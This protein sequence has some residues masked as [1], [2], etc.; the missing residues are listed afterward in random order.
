MPGPDRLILG[1]R[2]HG[3]GSARSVVAALD[4]AAPDCVL[5]EGPPDADGLIPLVTDPG[6]RPPVAILIYRPEEPARAVYYPFAEFS[7]EWQALCWARRHGVTARFMDLPQANRM[8][9]R[10]PRERRE[11]DPLEEL[12][13]AAGYDDGERWWEQLVEERRG[14]AGL[15]AGILE[16]MTAVRAKG[17]PAS[18]E[19]AVR[20]A[21]MRRV[22]RDAARTATRIA[23]VCGAWHAPMLATLPSAG[24]DAALLRG[25]PRVKVAATFVPWS[26]GR[27]TL[28][29]GY[30]AGIRSPGWYDHLWRDGSAVGWMTRV[31]R[32]MR[33][34]D[35]DASSGHVI[36]ALRLAEALAGLRGRYAVGLEELTEAAQAVLCFGVDLPMRLVRDKL[37]VGEALGQVP[38]HAPHV[39]LARDLAAQQRGLRLALDPQPRTLVL[40]LR[41]SL[42]RDRSHLLHRLR[43]L[44][45]PW[46]EVEEATGMGTFREAWRIAWDPELAVRVVEASLWGT[47]VA[48]AASARAIDIAARTPDLPRL[49]ALLDVALLA[50][51]PDAA[52]S[53]IHRLDAAAAVAAGMLQLMRALPPLANVLRYGSVRQTDTTVVAQ[54]V[55]TLLARICVGLPAASTS[56]DDAAAAELYD[57]VMA[58]DGALH[59]VG[60]PDQRADWLA[61]LAAVADA[62]AG[63]GLVAGRATRLLLDAGVLERAEVVRR[64]G[65]A[66]AAARDPDAAG[67]WAEGFLR[68]SG[69]L[70]LHDEALWDVVDRWLDGLTAEAF[71]QVLPVLRRTFASFPAA[72]RRQIGAHA[73]HGVA[74]EA[75]ARTDFAEARAR[76]VV[77]VIHRLLGRS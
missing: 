13:R 59:V 40:D 56:L 35:L 17:P 20:E 6:M 41:R 5:V 63:H 2:H 15:F 70:L 12:G 11:I 73:A 43:M 46:G 33:A 10:I 72:E 3:P 61:A 50:D 38:E 64:A 44:E 67:A 53:V 26:H 76:A 27:L 14:P 47:T 74:P 49:G 66:L 23:V 8:A 45:V 48:A 18:G 25:L 22:L 75:A 60:T 7:P 24:S 19:D 1:I 52:A 32:L 77:P 39:P 9:M 37:V 58:V 16:A 42:D 69:L 29:S 55:A 68:H 57:A 28:D 65:L 36:D 34:E 4:A 62:Q 21:A 31:A 54:V 51:L 30:G 71:A